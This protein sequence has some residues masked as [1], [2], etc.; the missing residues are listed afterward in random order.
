[1]VV[2]VVQLD[3]DWFGD[4]EVERT[5]FEN[6]W[7]DVVVEAIDC[8]GEGIPDHVGSADVLLSHD[9]DVDSAAMDATGCSVVTRYATGLDGI[10]VTAATDRGVRVTNVP[11]YCEDEVAEHILALALALVRR[12][13]RYDAETANG[14]WDWCLDSP[15]R[16]VSDLTMGFLAFGAKARAA[17]RRATEL[18]FAVEAHDPYLDDAEIR[19]VGATPVGF[20]ELVE[21]A[22]VLSINAPLTDDTR[23]LIGADVLSRMPAGS[24]LINTARG[25]IVDETALRAALDDGPLAGAGLDVLAEEPPEAD[26][27]LLGRSDVL[28]TPH[29][30]WYSTGSAAELRRKGSEYAI[31]AYERERSDGLVNPEALDAV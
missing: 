31:A 17:A 19:D 12:V 10:D 26:D 2:R 14:A 28:V 6:A 11:R 13:P 23:G 25:E 7:N 3:P 5:H 24:L 29:V 20:D 21:T 8:R 4:V 9:T 18:G 22:D 15:P 30:G 16:P 1:M 27:P